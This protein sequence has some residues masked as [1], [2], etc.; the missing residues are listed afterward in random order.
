MNRVLF[1]CVNGKRRLAKFTTKD[2]R[3]LYKK[4]RKT[5]T[6]GAIECDFPKGRHTKDSNM[7]KKIH[8]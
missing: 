1:Q 2:C 8:F 6:N 3:D 7:C 5:M 4:C